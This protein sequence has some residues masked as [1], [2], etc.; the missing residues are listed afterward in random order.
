MLIEFKLRG[1]K[2][3]KGHGGVRGGGFKVQ[4]AHLEAP[5]V[6]YGLDGRRAGVNIFSNNYVYLI[7]KAGISTMHCFKV[8]SLLM[9]GLFES[10]TISL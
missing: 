4:A 8:N 5:L 2:S 3:C 1:E 6:K 9:R 10:A 7:L